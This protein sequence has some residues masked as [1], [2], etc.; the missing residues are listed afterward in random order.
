MS[1]VDFYRETFMATAELVKNDPLL[2]ESAAAEM[3]GLKPQTLNSWRCTGR[4]GLEYV[5]VGRAIRYKL[6]AIQR[7]ISDNTV[8]VA[9]AD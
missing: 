3:L 5:R 9:T 4:Y 2:D 6:S 8:N 7:F 1:P